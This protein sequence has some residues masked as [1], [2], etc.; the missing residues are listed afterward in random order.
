[1]LLLPSLHRFG[2]LRRFRKEPHLA[3]LQ[4][5]DQYTRSSAF[6]LGHREYSV[7]RWA[8]RPMF[9]MFMYNTTLTGY[10]PYFIYPLLRLR[11]LCCNSIQYISSPFLYKV[12]KC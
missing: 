11:F 5:R 1:M 3:L 8:V 2:K 9:I 10:A 6:D 12:C 7:L 4:L